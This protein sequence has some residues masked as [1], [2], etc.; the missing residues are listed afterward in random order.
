MKSSVIGFSEERAAY[1]VRLEDELI[2]TSLLRD[3][4][5]LRC[6]AVAGE[7]IPGSSLELDDF[8]GGIAKAIAIRDY[9]REIGEDPDAPS[10]G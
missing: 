2:G 9:L 8:F 6:A 4:T 10:L 7:V 5:F 1:E 3:V